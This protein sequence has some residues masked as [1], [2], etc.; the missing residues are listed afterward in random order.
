MYHQH[1]PLGALIFALLPFMAMLPGR[2][3]RI[4]LPL[5]DRVQEYG[6]LPKSL[7]SRMGYREFFD[8]LVKHALPI[9][10]EFRSFRGLAFKRKAAEA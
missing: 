5:G 10:T 4:R 7:T 8:E 2:K 9:L 6:E 3:E 1:F